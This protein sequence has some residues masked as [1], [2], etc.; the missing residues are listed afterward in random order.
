MADNKNNNDDEVKPLNFPVVINQIDTKVP[1]W[2][3]VLY[4]IDWNRY[5]YPLINKDSFLVV[6]VLAMIRII[7]SRI[8][9]INKY[10]TKDKASQIN[11]T[12][13][14]NNN[15]A[16][17]DQM[18]NKY[19]ALCHYVNIKNV[20]KIKFVIDPRG[21]DTLYFDDNKEINICSDVYI[22]SRI[23]TNMNFTTYELQVYS[24]TI[25]YE[26]LNEFVE[27]CLNDYIRSNNKDGNRQIEQFYFKLNSYSNI[28]KTI[29]Y[30]EYNF[31]TN[32]SFDNIFF[33]DKKI[34]KKR[35]DVFLNNQE[36]YNRKG[37][38]YTLGFILYGYPGT[39]K[40][41][42]IKAIAK[43][44]GRHIIDISFNKIKKYS[45]LKTAFTEKRINNRDI[46]VGKRIYVFEDI[47]SILDAI[48]ERNLKN[49]KF[50]NG[51]ITKALAGTFDISPDELKNINKIM[52]NND[53]SITMAD[54]LNLLDG[55]VEPSG[56]ICIMTTNR[57]NMLDKAVI[58]PGRFDCHVFF[59]NASTS[60]ILQI[61]KHF[62]KEDLPE[63]QDIQGNN[64]ILVLENNVRSKNIKKSRNKS[65]NINSDSNKIEDT[66]NTNVETDNLIKKENDFYNKIHNV[67]KFNNKNIWSP[68]RI[69]QICNIYKDSPNYKTEIVEFMEKHY[70]EEKELL[71]FI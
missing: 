24:Y 41:S 55:C 62:Y 66:I 34:I 14:V 65:I 26:T 31:V 45:E 29:I 21:G 43:Y 30:D 61:I 11:L 42:T 44:T 58:R 35:L 39:G 56:R 1:Y 48:E 64:Q 13:T 71:K 6:T 57:Y 12:F 54:F 2:K 69:I 50:N 60:V 68:A 28:N 37:I 19:R 15:T 32:K 59:D 40:T 16:N 20:E 9:F 70:D 10:I 3:H 53:D 23:I 7:V 36:W 52:E 5:I 46:P 63:S 8:Y 47:E 22:D 27:N 51:N 67:S 49:N 17:A 18:F 25:K 38:P 33:K 4:S